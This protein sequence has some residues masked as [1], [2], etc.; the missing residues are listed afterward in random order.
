MLSAP[1][2]DGPVIPNLLTGGTIVGLLFGYGV[3]YVHA[4]WRRAR[5]D[6]RTTKAA[7]PKM[8]QAKWA[9]WRMMVQRGT[10]VAAVVAG[11]IAWIAVAVG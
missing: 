5:T 9:A 10:L 2:T 4:V 11:L 8:K 7:V 6:Y 1:L 3:G